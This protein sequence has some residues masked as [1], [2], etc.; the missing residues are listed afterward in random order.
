MSRP[1]SSDSDPR[2]PGS[3]FAKFLPKTFSAAQWISPT[4]WA[5]QA[6]ENEMMK[7][8]EASQRTTLGE[9]DLPPETKHHKVV[10]DDGGEIHVVEIGQGA[11]I[12]LLH[13]VLL[14]VAT[15]PHQ[16]RELSRHHRVIAVDQRGHGRSAP[17][18]EGYSIDRLG[19]D[20]LDVLDALGV[21]D[22]VLVGH[23][24]GGMVSMSVAIDNSERL[25]QH[26]S[27]LVLVATS[28]DPLFNLPG[29]SVFVRLVSP[30]VRLGIEVLR[31]RNALADVR[32]L[33]FMAARV[34][35]GGNPSP[36]NLEFAKA[37]IR[38]ASARLIGE[39]WGQLL[40]YDVTDRLG[41]ITLP[42]TV[43]V[44]DSDLLT[45]PWHSIRMVRHIPNANLIRFAECG[46]MV[47]FER[48]R[49]MNRVIL[50]FARQVQSDLGG[51]VAR[52]RIT[53]ATA[54]KKA[55]GGTP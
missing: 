31:G 42:T 11:P 43:I 38:A 10:T 34:I 39:L 13:G 14:S 6:I 32:P 1:R 41:E 4:R 25:A 3:P 15:W 5:E 24:M 21:R 16:L 20:L 50:N 19:R 9:L 40:V 47:M 45:P 37:L 7:R 23:S 2:V 12:V 18:L 53:R 46:H 52:R 35:L 8:P 30:W 29:L 48:H 33:R 51:T 17:G 28:G 55:P 49:E 27:G 36:A 44:G 26:V 54:R 22:A